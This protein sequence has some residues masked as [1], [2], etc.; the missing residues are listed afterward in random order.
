[1]DKNKTYLY[2]N[3]VG[4][5][6]AL[7]CLFNKEKV[8]ETASRIINFNQN[9][10]ILKLINQVLK[11]SRLNLKNI[12]GIAVVNGPGRF[13][14]IRTGLSIANTLAYFLQIPI[15][16]LSINTFQTNKKYLEKLVNKIIKRKVGNLVSPFYGKNPNITSPNKKLNKLIK[17]K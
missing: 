7:I 3:T 8:L 17:G 15:I 6:K 1:M 16:N 4:P 2:I 9:Q 14:S 13:S 5:N 10:S 11:K 12:S